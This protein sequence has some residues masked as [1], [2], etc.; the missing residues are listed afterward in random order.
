MMRDVWWARCLYLAMA[1]YCLFGIVQIR[2]KP[3]LQYD[4]AMLVLGA[5][6]MRH[7][8][9]QE[10]N[11]AHD[12]DTWIQVRSRWFPLMTVRYVGAVKEYLAA[13]LFAMFGTRTSL[14]RLLSMALGLIGIWGF[15]GLLRARV[16]T[17]TAALAALA[18]AINPAYVAMTVFDNGTV[19]VFM[20]SLGLLC[21]AL[22]RYLARATV[23]A[24][25]CVGLAVGFGTWAR[26]NFVWA[27][28]AILL[29]I[30]IVA[31]RKL[32]EVPLRHWGAALA[33]A[34]L[35]S[36][37]LIVYQVISHGGT[38]E[39][40]SM[41][42]S[43]DSLGARLWTRLVMF[44]ETLLCDREHRAMWNGP[45]MPAWQRWL[46]P[47]V[48]LAA[49][50]ACLRMREW[51]A[52]IVAWSFVFFAAALFFSRLMVA[53]HHLVALV[54]FAATM[55]VMALPARW[56]LWIV[57]GVYAACAFSWQTAAVAGLRATG[58]VGPWS[59]G[60]VTLATR[61]EQSYADRTIKILD[62]GLQYNLY[63]ITDARLHAVE[64]Y[65]GP[66]RDWTE[67]LRQGGVFLYFAPAGRQMPETTNAFLA[68]LGEAAPVAHR[69]S[70]PQRDGT[71]WAELLEVEPNTLHQ[72][73]GARIAAG[74]AASADRLEGFYEIEEGRWR[75]SRRS[76]AI[77]FDAPALRGAPSARL[78]L[79][80]YLPEAEIQK[81]G[82]ITLSARVNGHA[83]QPEVYSRPGSVTFARG[84]PAEWLGAGPVRV[85]FAV[86][87]SMQADQRELGI[88]LVSAALD[89]PAR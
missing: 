3:G 46:F 38:F 35:G 17:R 1:L 39:A 8:P 67:E 71:P 9:H 11:L 31:R 61:L 7:L 27:A 56:P 64:I 75:W 33:G 82:P 5:V 88:V 60:I 14:I 66:P 21:L 22:R 79:E 20:A 53:E 42:V 24:A 44:A 4:E 70:V 30:V 36:L 29:A 69:T 32:L 19:S 12:P 52:R 55:V 73:G 2:Q 80:L 15:T 49:C 41:F 40:A 65:G 51:M 87:K 6:H 26:V 10:L 74:N 37:P 85:E 25:F 84:L 68:A 54:P 57:G 89:T 45:F 28:G 77:R 76:F 72:G 83:L 86:D 13:P 34:A 48:V 63:T 16:G 59:D 43:H 62:W 58:G 50:A 47:A 18:V 81:L 78:S 23:A